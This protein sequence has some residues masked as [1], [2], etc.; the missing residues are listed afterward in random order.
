MSCAIV[1]SVNKDVNHSILTQLF[2]GIF[3]FCAI[4]NIISSVHL[5]KQSS[6]LIIDLLIH[7]EEKSPKD[8]KAVLASADAEQDSKSERAEE[9]TT[10]T[11]KDGEK[12]AE[13]VKGEEKPA[14]VVSDGEKSADA[15]EESSEGQS[16]GGE[17]PA[18]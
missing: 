9:S 6:F 2:I 10:D 7:R 12:S 4:K 17:N 15:A 5:K 14:A 18:G 16:K 13:S 3:N 1:G 11:A 8:S